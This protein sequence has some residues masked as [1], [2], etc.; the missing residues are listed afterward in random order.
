MLVYDYV[1]LKEDLFL[2]ITD[3][4]K[5]YKTDK[6]KS[7]YKVKGQTIYKVDIDGLVQYFINSAHPV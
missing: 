7:Y 4:I 6:H 2:L 3:G 5:P 1:E